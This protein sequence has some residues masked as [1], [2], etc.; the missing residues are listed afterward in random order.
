MTRARTGARPQ[1][2][3]C[4]PAWR[5][6]L[7]SRLLVA[8]L[9]LPAAP[10]LALVQTGAERMPTWVTFPHRVHPKAR[11]E[12]LYRGMAL[13]CEFPEQIPPRTPNPRWEDERPWR[14]H[15]VERMNPAFSRCLLR[16]FFSR[17]E[18]V[19]HEIE[20][21]LR[22]EFEKSV[23]PKLGLAPTGERVVELK[24]R[25]FLENGRFPLPEFT[26]SPDQG[27]RLSLTVH[28][29]L[30]GEVDLQVDSRHVLRIREVRRQDLNDAPIRRGW[31][32][33]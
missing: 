33:R 17:P 18:F 4:A 20:A 31:D 22:M 29:K 10:A 15:F 9:M 30:V 13:F 32:L 23:P 28:G 25:I 12:A 11:E 26:G 6:R 21:V 27:V 14:L 2:G 1:R 7:L 5:A 19:D 8:A 3:R 16:V 24:Q